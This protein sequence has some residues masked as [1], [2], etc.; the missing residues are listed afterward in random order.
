MSIRDAVMAENLTG[1]GYY[2]SVKG[3]R[4]NLNPLQLYSLPRVKTTGGDVPKIWAVVKARKFSWGIGATAIYTAVTP[5]YKYVWHIDKEIFDVTDGSLAVTTYYGMRSI[6][7]LPVSWEV[8]KSSQFTIKVS[9]QSDYDTE[10]VATRLPNSKDSYKHKYENSTNPYL[11]DTSQ[12]AV[13][14]M[15]SFMCNIIAHASSIGSNTIT[16][17]LYDRTILM[18]YTGELQANNDFSLQIIGVEETCYA[19][20]KPVDRPGMYLD[21]VHFLLIALFSNSLLQNDSD[22]VLEPWM[23]WLAFQWYCK[24]ANNKADSRQI[25]D[26]SPRW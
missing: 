21:K 23:L 24:P 9:T 10:L 15:L 2:S 7:D 14:N 26:I 4:P 17:V 1:V 8:F 5:D 11:D 12:H 16:S 18:A 25:F 6:R 20:R 3:R 22:I 13:F 19:N